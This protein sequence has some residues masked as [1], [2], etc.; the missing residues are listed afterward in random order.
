[1]NWKHD[2]ASQ[3]GLDCRGDGEIGNCHRFLKIHSA[4]PPQTGVCFAKSGGKILVMMHEGPSADAA[5]PNALLARDDSANRQLPDVRLRQN[6]LEF[7]FAGLFLES[8]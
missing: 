7:D 1:M 6:E 5:M 8:L 4:A 3:C 2:W